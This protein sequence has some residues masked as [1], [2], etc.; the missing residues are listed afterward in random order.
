MRL[1]N[2]QSKRWTIGI[3]AVSA[4]VCACVLTAALSTTGA[5]AQS[6]KKPDGGQ[7]ASTPQAASA[8][9]SISTGSGN[10]YKTTVDRKTE[11]ELSAEDFRQASLFTSRIVLHLNKAALCLGGEKNDQAR[12]ELEKGLAL[13]GMVRR[14]LPTTTV[15]TIVRDKDGKEVYRYVDR[16]QEDR[17]PLHE[18]LI[19]VN[20]ME[21][22]TDAKQGEAAVRGVRLADAELLHTS[23]LVKLDYVESKLN[24]A[25]R[26]LKDK[27]EDALAQLAMAQSQ[28]VDYVVNKQDDPLV[29]A[30]MALQVAE[31]M[32]EEGRE[33][34][35][36]ANLQVAKNYL[37]FYRGLLPAGK[38][39]HVSKLE[40]EITKLQGE[41]GR[42]GAASTIRGFWD[43][44]ASWFARKP[45][46]TRA[47]GAEPATK[48]AATADAVVTAGK[49]AAEQPKK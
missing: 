27:P 24:R 28:G 44:V 48:T 12:E 1:T 37:E 18:G 49:D 47:T 26:L 36:K 19:A 10:Q 41:I 4:I 11:G 35:A 33:E 15:T 14:L 22:I 45:G 3:T 2:L 21:P 6:E 17:I 38:S 7:T 23:I 46:E 39:E 43:R 29:K 42:K 16:V 20:T 8:P 32:S 13:V 30:Q 9:T 25:L 5:E 34:A 40:G 31:R